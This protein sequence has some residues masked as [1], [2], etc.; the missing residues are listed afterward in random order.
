M[1]QILHRMSHNSLRLASNSA[2]VTSPL[3]SA[4]ANR[5]V[6]L[7]G[8]G[9]GSEGGGGA[10]LQSAT[11]R[12]KSSLFFHTVFP[13]SLRRETF[14]VSV[15]AKFPGFAKIYILVIIFDLFLN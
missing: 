11:H 15:Y 9:E 13:D 1:A 10:V 7:G 12:L 2:E 5:G 4:A 14:V 8:R 3:L 6:G